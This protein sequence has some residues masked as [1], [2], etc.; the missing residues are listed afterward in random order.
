MTDSSESEAEATS[1]SEPLPQGVRRAAR[2]P[3][4]LVCDN[5]D[6]KI[7]LGKPIIDVIDP[8]RWAPAYLSSRSIPAT[9][10]KD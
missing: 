7:N 1:D 5:A 2:S 10:A 4:E 3:N 9:C 8:L 6:Y